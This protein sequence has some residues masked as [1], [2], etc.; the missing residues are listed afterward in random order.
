M[1]DTTE[2]AWE[3]RKREAARKGARGDITYDE[4]I[5]VFY[6]A[7]G[8]VEPSADDAL[9]VWHA[10]GERATAAMAD[11][12]AMTDAE[13]AGWRR[14]LRI[15]TKVCNTLLIALVFVALPALLWSIGAMQE[16]SVIVSLVGL[17]YVMFDLVPRILRRWCY[18][19]KS[20]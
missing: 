13:F 2:Q 7:H 17:G 8:V 14:R 20:S 1:A 5:T 12:K 19:R 15:I 6:E 10:W 3:L 18:H 4:M 11:A 9:E 16:T